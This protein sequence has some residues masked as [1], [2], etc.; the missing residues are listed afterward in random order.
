[1]GQDLVGMDL[2]DLA[3]ALGPGEPGFRARQLYDAL[4][5]QKATDLGRITTLPRDLKSRLNEQ[6]RVGLPEV[7]AQYG[8]KDGTQRYLLKLA[9]ERTVETVL[10]P[11]EDRYTLCISSQ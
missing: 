6:F 3:T 1:M 8:S 4:Y 5:R 9:D 10:M 11:E 2:S 7:S